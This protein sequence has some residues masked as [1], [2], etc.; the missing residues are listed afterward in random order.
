MEFTNFATGTLFLL[1]QKL[2][3]IDNPHEGLFMNYCECG[4]N[5]TI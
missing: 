3:Q 2:T 4:M 1:D 5:G